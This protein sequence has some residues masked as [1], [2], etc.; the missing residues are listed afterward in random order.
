LEKNNC[1]R[2]A[3]THHQD[4]GVKAASGNGLH[5]GEDI[6]IGGNWRLA[7][8]FALAIGFPS[9]R[10]VSLSSSLDFRRPF[11]HIVEQGLKVSV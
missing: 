8:P 7:C 3:T 6:L 2:S 4:A 5:T 10:P 1:R 11:L 9:L